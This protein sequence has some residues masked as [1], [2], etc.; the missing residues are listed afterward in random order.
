[1]AHNRFGRH[2]VWVDAA[3]LHVEK[4]GLTIKVNNAEVR[5]GTLKVTDTHISWMP[6]GKRTAKRLTWT[7]FSDLMSK[8]S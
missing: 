4:G 5:V 3:C 8:N 6:N 1:M 7:E 2:D